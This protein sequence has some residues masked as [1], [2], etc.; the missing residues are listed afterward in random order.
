MQLS[1]NIFLL[2]LMKNHILWLIP[3]KQINK[4]KKELQELKGNFRRNMPESIKL[5]LNNYKKIV[6][7]E[8]RRLQ[9]EKKF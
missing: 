8:L 6:K 5:S 7:R 3:R 4:S 1:L 2:Q 9:E